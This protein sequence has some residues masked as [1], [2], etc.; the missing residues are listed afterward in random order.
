MSGTGHITACMVRL[1]IIDFRLWEYL[2]ENQ[3]V[4]D[5]RRISFLC[6]GIE[7]PVLPAKFAEVGSAVNLS[8]GG[9]KKSCVFT[10]LSS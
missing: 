4:F 2:L 10:R 5:I 9:R 6:S 8:C 3:A 7:N 1:E